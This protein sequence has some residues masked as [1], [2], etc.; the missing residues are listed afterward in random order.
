M[1]LNISRK[2]QNSAQVFE[3]PIK[4]ALW[5]NSR[6]RS[7]NSCCLLQFTS[8]SAQSSETQITVVLVS[9][10]EKKKKKMLIIFSSKQAC[11]NNRT[12]CSSAS[13]VPFVLS[14]TKNSS[15]AT[16]MSSLW[17]WQLTL[18]VQLTDVYEAFCHLY[19]RLWSIQKKQF[20][21]KTSNMLSTAPPVSQYW[22]SCLTPH[23]GHGMQ[24][25][26]RDFCQ[27]LERKNN[28]KKQ[29][30]TSIQKHFTC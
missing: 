24:R 2:V 15:K 5:E 6:R 13:D 7:W 11:N 30:K 3:S 8:K 19:S 26:L 18:S 17:H 20:T 10:K 21:I 23:R 29:N 25:G 12:P 27:T 28:K 9:W 4:E 14:N 16:V 22:A 1:G